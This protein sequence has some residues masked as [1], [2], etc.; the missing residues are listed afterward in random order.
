MNTD[1]HIIVGGLGGG[2]DVGLALLLARSA[3]IPLEQGLGGE[4]PQLHS[5]PR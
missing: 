1:N 5:N 4:L 2:G 3:G